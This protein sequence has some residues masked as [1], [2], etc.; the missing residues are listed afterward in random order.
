MNVV[1]FGFYFEQV[2]LKNEK[3]FE[4]DVRR[5]MTRNGRSIRTSPTWHNVPISLFQLFLAVYERGGFLKVHEIKYSILYQGCRC[6]NTL[7]CF[8]PVLAHLN[9]SSGRAFVVTL[10]SASAS[11]LDVLVEVV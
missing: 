10:S 6:L 2:Y 4:H 9:E 1:F 8:W 7:L 3:A 5:F 11:G